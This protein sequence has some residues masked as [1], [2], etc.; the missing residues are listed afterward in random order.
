M[1]CG[2]KSIREM[3]PQ[4]GGRHRA[5]HDHRAA[6]GLGVPRGRERRRLRQGHRPDPV[7]PEPPAQFDGPRRL[8]PEGP[9]AQLQRVQAEVRPAVTVPA[10]ATVVLEAL[11]RRDRQVLLAGL[12]VVIALA[13]GWLLL[14]A[15]M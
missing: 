3:S 12:S 4:P 10:A 14:G 5:P 8:G 7:R 1:L 2:A 15:G 9:R 6:A 11:L 13:W